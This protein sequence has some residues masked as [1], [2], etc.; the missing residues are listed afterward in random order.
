MKE[1][2]HKNLVAWHKSMALVTEIYSLT[3]K[4]PKEETYGLTSQIR[5]AAVSIPSNLAEG[6]AMKSTVHYL[7]F[8]YIARGS[9]AEVETQ[10]TIAGNLSYIAE[11][12]LNPMLMKADELGKMLSKLVASL[13]K[14][15]DNDVAN[16]RVPD[17]ESLAP[18]N[19]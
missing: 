17:I 10:L 12:E 13:N 18:S 16:S 11:T 2:S 1:R 19:L 5:R 8:I 4:F 9:L 6:H 3:K 7:K 14:K 15:I